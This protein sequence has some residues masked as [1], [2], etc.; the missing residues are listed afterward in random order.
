MLEQLGHFTIVQVGLKCAHLSLELTESQLLIRV[1][2]D[3]LE[4]SGQ[5]DVLLLDVLLQLILNDPY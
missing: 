3:Q 5:C 1:R 4:Q 2:V